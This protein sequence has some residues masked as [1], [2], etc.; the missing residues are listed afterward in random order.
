MGA[1]IQ[2]PGPKGA[3]FVYAWAVRPGDID[4]VDPAGRIAFNSGN[5][6]YAMNADGSAQTPLSATQF[7]AEEH[8]AW[9]PDG[10]RIAFNRS[11]DSNNVSNVDIYVMNA[12]GSNLIRLTT[13]ASVDSE[14]TWSP[15]GAYIAFQ[16]DR[17]DSATV[18]KSEI[19]VMKA[20]G[21]AQVRLTNLPG[22]TVQPR[23]QSGA[24]SDDDG[25][26]NV[27]DNCSLAANPSQCDSDG[28]GYGNG[29]DGDMNNNGSVNAQDTTLFK[30]QLGQPSVGPAFNKA[31]LNCNGSINAQDTVLF[32][33]RIGSPPGP[34]GVNP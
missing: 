21:S 24:D 30:A 31:D 14:P 17:D 11:R 28:D 4:D 23:W 25:H 16:S 3:N 22:D 9:S 12:D 19:Y 10:T 13:D 5:D 7:V 27:Y 6:V 33:Q 18:K 2:Q 1:G 26:I 8:P 29:C 32:R 20:D 34:S 15:D